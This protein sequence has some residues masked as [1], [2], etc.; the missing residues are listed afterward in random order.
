MTK[1]NVI[2]VQFRTET[3][4]DRMTG[5][6][7]DVFRTDRAQDVFRARHNAAMAKLAQR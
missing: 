1:S 5:G 4:A 7:G 3:E 2:E 6:V